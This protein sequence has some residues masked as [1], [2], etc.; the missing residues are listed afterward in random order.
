MDFLIY[1]PFRFYFFVSS[2]KE[3]N[4]IW[5]YAAQYVLYGLYITSKAC[6]L[7]ILK[8]LLK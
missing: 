2:T 7:Q 8:H 3:K 1:I 5:I 6:F 4:T